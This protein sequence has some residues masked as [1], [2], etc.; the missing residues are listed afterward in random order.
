MLMLE[1]WVVRGGA[2]DDQDDNSTLLVDTTSAHTL[3]DQP[4]PSV[5]TTIIEIDDKE[6]AYPELLTNSYPQHK[7]ISINSNIPVPTAIKP[8]VKFI[9]LPRSW[10]PESV[11]PIEKNSLKPSNDHICPS[12]ATEMLKE[13]PDDTIIYV[14][15][16]S[17]MRKPAQML[18]ESCAVHSCSLYA[19]IGMKLC[20]LERGIKIGVYTVQNNQWSGLQRKLEVKLLSQFKSLLAALYHPVDKDGKVV[21]AAKVEITAAQ[22]RYTASRLAQM[23]SQLGQCCT[24]STLFNW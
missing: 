5:S 9:H 7:M 23:G 21:D 8:N 14:I 16:D 10:C 2:L 19:M 1:Q 6:V 4:V 18:C 12:S 24:I 13:I 17:L 11:D 20:E 3:Q 15:G 22:D